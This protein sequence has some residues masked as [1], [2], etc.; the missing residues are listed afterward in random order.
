MKLRAFSLLLLL[1][2]PG[3]AIIAQTW[4]IE[5]DPNRDSQ[6]ATFAKRNII[7]TSIMECVYEHFARNP[8]AEKSKIT[9]YIL[10][11]GKNASRYSVYGTYQRDSIVAKDYPDGITFGK[12]ILLTKKYDG[13]LNEIICY[14]NA[15][16]ISCYESLLFDKYMY[17]EPIPQRDWTLV[18]E[19][20]EICGQECLKA[21]CLFRGREWTAW[22]CPGIEINGGPWKFSGLPGLILKVE[23]SEKEH[24]FEAFQIRKSNKKFGHR[25]NKDLIKTSR[26]TFNKLQAGYHKDSRAF[27]DGNTLIPK[28]SA[29]GKPITK[30]GKKKFYN[31][32]EK[33]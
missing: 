13:N 29:D 1:L 32:I 2:L 9:D 14:K 19:K 28:T 33:D 8:I 21:T 31:P 26:K 30:K 11:I 27:S 4:R 20:D 22:Y 10:E 24:I 23:D 3:H 18:N 5:A 25:I 16:K 17:D 7:D 12:Y 6:P 15:N